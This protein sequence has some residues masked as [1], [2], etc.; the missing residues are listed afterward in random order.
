M[1]DLRHLKIIED[2]QLCATI[3]ESKPLYLTEG[4]NYLIGHDDT[5]SIQIKL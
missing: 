4:F 5:F 3:S 2:R 1:L